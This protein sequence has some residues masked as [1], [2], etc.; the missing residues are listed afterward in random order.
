MRLADYLSQESLKPGEFAKRIG[1]SPSTVTRYLKGERTPRVKS[2]YRI[3]AA[4]GGA[5]R[6]RDFLSDGEAASGS[7]PP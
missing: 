5:V 4:T 2:M 7:D 6:A 1:A 3:E